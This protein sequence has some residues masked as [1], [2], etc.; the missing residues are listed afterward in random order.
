MFGTTV[1]VRPGSISRGTAHQFN[2]DRKPQ[3]VVIDCDT[4]EVSSHEILA[5]KSADEVFIEKP[6]IKVRAEE[7]LRSL[8]KILKESSRRKLGGSSSSIEEVLDSLE[9]TKSV[10]RRLISL[11]RESGVILEGLSL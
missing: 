3:Y 10:K 11:L 5:A 6:L 2:K 1:C 8:V 9:C 4:G 7:E